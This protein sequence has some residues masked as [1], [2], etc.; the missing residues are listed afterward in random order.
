M[1]KPLKKTDKGNR[2]ITDFFTPKST[3][4]TPSSSQPA[5][6]QPSLSQPVSLK[7]IGFKPS[8]KQISKKKTQDEAAISIDS[9]SGDDP[10]FVPSKTKRCHVSISHDDTSDS[11]AVLSGPAKLS[12]V[13]RSK[14][15][16]VKPTV[17]RPAQSSAKTTVKRRAQPA[18][19][20]TASSATF[21]PL[22]QGKR[23]LDSSDSSDGEM[24][25]PDPTALNAALTRAPVPRVAPLP[26]DAKG[27]ARAEAPSSPSGHSTSPKRRRLSLRD[28]RKRSSAPGDGSEEEVPSSVSAEE[29]LVLPQPSPPDPKETK[30]NIAKWR[31]ATSTESSGREHSPPL[32]DYPSTSPFFSSPAYEIAPLPPNPVPDVET[33]LDV[34]M[35]DAADMLARNGPLR[36]NGSEAEVSQQLYPHQSSSLSPV[37]PSPQPSPRKA[38]CVLSQAANEQ[39][40]HTPLPPDGISLPPLP[41]TPVALDAETKT[42]LFL[43]RVRAEALEAA[44]REQ[45]ADSDEEIELQSISDSDDDDLLMSFVKTKTIRPGTPPKHANPSSASGAPQLS[46]ASI[47]QPEAGPSSRYSFRNREPIQS[48]KRRSSSP[49]NDAKTHARPDPSKKRAINPLDKLLR[50]KKKQ[51]KSGTGIED[52][53]R[54]EAILREGTRGTNKDSL[55]EEMEREED[56]DDDG[57]WPDE[58]AAMGAVRRRARKLE[59]F[60][61]SQSLEDDDSD[62]EPAELDIVEATKHLGDEQGEAVGKILA[63]DRTGWLLKGKNKKRSAKGLSLW[64]RYEPDSDSMEEHSESRLRL[65]FEKDV[66][67]NNRVLSLI[68]AAVA[69]EDWCC[70]STLL[71]T[72]LISQCQEVHKPALINWLF[73]IGLH[74]NEEVSGAAYTCLL[75]LAP[76]IGTSCSLSTAL[77][78][79]LQ[80]LG[81]KT[82][83]LNACV[84]EAPAGVRPRD[85]S[86]DIRLERVSRMVTV[87]NTFARANAVDV[88][89]VPNIV[90]ALL[91]IGFALSSESELC[92]EIMDAIDA[93]GAAVP[94]SSTGHSDMEPTLC[95]RIL[96]FAKDLTPVNKVHLLSMFS[97]ACPLMARVSRWLSHGLLLGDRVLHEQ[98]YSALPALEPI[99]ELLS[100]PGGSKAM[101]DVVSGA[102]QDNYFDDLLCYVQVL[103]RAFKDVPAYV[104]EEKRLAAANSQPVINGAAPAS[105]EKPKTELQRIKHCLDVLH[106]KI[107]DTR[108][109]H[110]DRSRVK[111]A[112]QQLAFRIFYTREAALKWY[113][114]AR[115]ANLRGYFPKPPA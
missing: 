43:E 70:L 106:G 55:L 24:F 98:P 46:A 85:I 108:A 73:T 1:S 30:D 59:S 6:S 78:S 65:P 64:E 71:I 74:D 62:E 75:A 61:L 86:P 83:L 69:R 87:A 56:S 67:E 3:M 114:P 97:G 33:D 89:D 39:R 60:P 17:S 99:V 63:K 53:R 105:P 101:F 18:A 7:K 42:R 81:M 57:M 48:N 20:M 13:T 40:P 10:V 112:L 50:E 92:M 91:L 109:A 26:S 93:L 29:E 115:P 107:V 58:G 90:M 82:S 96:E 95:L 41:P 102:E 103:S 31:L 5:S 12:A 2:S 21:R 8:T 22:T 52:L 49:G 104:Q 77:V 76:Q 94:A 88:D 25:K 47:Q 19:T 16:P 15:A 66:I 27:K 11:V 111:A 36:R 32:S 9:G 23:K 72:E 80:E 68:D 45:Q 110:L 4:G 79:C 34:D 37:P 38:T 14:A 44:R 100:P 84:S 113:R 54:A 35:A 51:E 28:T